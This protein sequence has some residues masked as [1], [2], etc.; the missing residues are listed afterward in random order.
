MQNHLTRDGFDVDS[1]KT[2]FIFGSKC[3]TVRIPRRSPG[4]VAKKTTI[5]LVRAII[6]VQK[7]A[8]LFYGF[9][10][11]VGSFLI[12]QLSWKP[13]R[14]GCKC[15]AWALPILPNVLAKLLNYDY[16]SIF[17][18]YYRSRP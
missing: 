13:S 14:S 4:T 9:I 11:Q 5:L 6:A 17:L 3:P 15:S 12:R 16:S 1:P 7:F 18:Y 2:F 8:S 10:F